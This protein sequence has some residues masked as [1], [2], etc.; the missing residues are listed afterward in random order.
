MEQ[1]AIKT[2]LKSDSEKTPIFRC[3][4]AQYGCDQTWAG[5]AKKCVYPHSVQCMKLD[6]VDPTLRDKI[7]DC[8]AGMSLSERVEATEKR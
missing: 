4:G 3:A 6:L 1:A 2:T 8:V 7:R 5:R